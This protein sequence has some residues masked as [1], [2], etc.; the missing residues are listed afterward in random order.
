MVDVALGVFTNQGS[1]G[2]GQDGTL[3]RFGRRRGIRGK[4]AGGRAGDV[5]CRH[6]GSR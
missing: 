1:V 3:G 5:R 2:L 4:E 6:G